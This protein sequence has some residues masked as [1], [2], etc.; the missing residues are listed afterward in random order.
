MG[1]TFS[2]KDLTR[3]EIRDVIRQYTDI[4]FTITLI[5]NINTEETRVIVMLIVTESAKE[6]LLRMQTVRVR[7]RRR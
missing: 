5:K 7:Q 2:A 6:C 1:I 3:G 4:D